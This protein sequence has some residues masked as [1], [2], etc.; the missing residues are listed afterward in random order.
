MS[1]AVGEVALGKCRP[2]SAPFPQRNER[3]SLSVPK[4]LEEDVR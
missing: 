2:Q 3:D 4:H 1:G